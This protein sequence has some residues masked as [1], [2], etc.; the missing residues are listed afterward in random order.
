MAG[1]ARQRWWGW[2]ELDPRWAERLV[3]DAGIQ[4]GDLVV[5][6]GAGHGAITRALVDAGAAK[7][8][9]V[10]LHSGRADALRR[11][12]RDHAHRVVVVNADAADLR[13]TRR[14]YRV[15]ANPPFAVSTAI[16]RRLLAPG[17]RLLRADLILPRPVVARWSA[18][19][20][21]GANRWTRE[22]IVEPGLHL[23][24]SALRP[25]PPMPV[26]TLRIVSRR[27]PPTSARRP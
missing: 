16:L 9:A 1:R 22:F 23:P 6:V 7:V 12:F 17:S 24:P 21:P 4:R 25:P 2:H 8:I 3:A 20:A 11:R 19:R 18:G 13:L 14:P 27:R 10:E 15:V 26:G 5:D